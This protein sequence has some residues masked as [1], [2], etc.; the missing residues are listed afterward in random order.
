[1]Y[2]CNKYSGSHKIYGAIVLGPDEKS[3]RE[4][5]WVVVNFIHGNGLLSTD[6]SE[7]M[8]RW[9]DK[10]QETE[11]RSTGQNGHFWLHV[12]TAFTLP[13]EKMRNQS[14]VI[15]SPGFAFGM[16]SIVANFNWLRSPG[17]EGK[18]LYGEVDAAGWMHLETT[19]GNLYHSQFETHGHFHRIGAVTFPVG[20]AVAIYF[21]FFFP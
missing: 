1:M 21:D 2:K 4:Y 10:Q 5:V 3:A 12:P 16:I 9:K 19:D 8:Q 20:A 11:T 18:Q 6:R 15:I 7:Q 13:K 17:K 14:S